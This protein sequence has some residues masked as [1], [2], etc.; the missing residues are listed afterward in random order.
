MLDFDL[1]ELYEV[2]TKRLN[3]QGKRNSDKFP[4][5]F[6]FRLTENEWEFIQLKSSSAPENGN[7]S[8]IATGSENGNSSQIVMSSEINSSSQFVM[9]GLF[10]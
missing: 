1:A 2:A 6:M 8:Q 9:M 7:W 5:D 10:F 3:E 4:E